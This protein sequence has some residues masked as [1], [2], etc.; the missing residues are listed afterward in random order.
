[1]NYCDLNICI[2]IYQKKENFTQPGNSSTPNQTL[3][4]YVIKKE[5]EAILK[6]PSLL[7]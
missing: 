4:I 2:I 3:P 5:E 7:T 1:M 6:R